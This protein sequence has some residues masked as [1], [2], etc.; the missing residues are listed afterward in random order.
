MRKLA[1]KLFG[2]HEKGWPTFPNTRRQ[3]L[4]GGLVCLVIW[5]GSGLLLLWTGQLRGDME[6][7]SIL[8]PLLLLTVLGTYFLGQG[9]VSTRERPHFVRKAKKHMP[10]RKQ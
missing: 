7:Y 3:L 2:V 1:R 10:E 9:I 5:P 8:S 6:I 4:I